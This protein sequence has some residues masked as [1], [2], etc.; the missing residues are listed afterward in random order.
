M[1]KAKDLKS[2]MEESGLAV[3][4]TQ[5]RQEGGQT[6]LSDHRPRPIS[7]T[8]RALPALGSHVLPSKIVL[9]TDKIHGGEAD[10]SPGAKASS[11]SLLLF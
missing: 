1:L 7:E 4:E 3:K 5:S 11:S 9:M 8:L 6:C 2:D 10:K